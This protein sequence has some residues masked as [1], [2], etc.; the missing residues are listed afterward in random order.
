M[1]PPY[2]RDVVNARQSGRHPDMVLIAIAPRERWFRIDDHRFPFVFVPEDQ[3]LAGRFVWWW[4]A[5]V[6]VTLYA[7][8]SSE[9]TWLHLAGKL[10][11]FAA[12]VIISAACAEEGEEVDA[13]MRR[14]RYGT[15]HAGAPW[16]EFDPVTRWPQ[17]WSEARDLAY[18]LA[19]ERWIA[20]QRARGVAA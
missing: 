12:P 19:R 18:S 16:L 9:A 6:P 1:L 13:L 17:F 20:E 11:E 7:E 4:L 10:A 15:L 3:Y 14:L 8:S 2:A 5:G